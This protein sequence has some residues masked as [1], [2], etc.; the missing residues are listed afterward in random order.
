M[1][2][3]V[4]DEIIEIM[5]KGKTGFHYFKDRYALMLLADVVND[6]VKMADLRHSPWAKLLQKPLVKQICAA[7]GNGVLKQSDFDYLWPDA[8]KQFLLTLSRWGGQKPSWQQTSR[9]GY[10]WCYS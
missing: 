10:N 3:Q 1:E 8:T 4:I 2:Q 5:P 7:N 6:G 9:K